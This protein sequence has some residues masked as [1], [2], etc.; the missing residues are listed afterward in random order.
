MANAKK[1]LSSCQ[2]ARDL[3]LQQK[4]AWH[5]MMKIRA[6]MADNSSLLTG[7]VEADETYLG[8]KGKKDYDR[9]ED[10]PRKRGRGTMKDAVI[11]AVSRAGHVVAQLI[12]DISGETIANFIRDNVDTENATLYTDQYTGYNTIGKEME[13]ETLNRSE[14]WEKVRCIPTRLKASGLLSNVH[15]MD[16]III[17]Q[18]VTRHCILQKRATNI[19]TEERTSLPSFSQRVWSPGKL[20]IS[21]VQND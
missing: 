16:R 7:I 15:G 17:T 12:P 21:Q 3:G 6:E 14:Q 5:L 18:Q 9:T 4:A 11:G 20:K 19:T 13:H 8:G 2:L 1:S 10:E